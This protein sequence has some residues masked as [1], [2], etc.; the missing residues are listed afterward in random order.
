MDAHLHFHPIDTNS[1]NQA[2]R[3]NVAQALREDIGDGDISASLIGP[4]TQAKARVIT[5]Q[6]IPGCRVMTRA[7]AWVVGPI[8]LAE[9][10]PSP[11]SSR[12]A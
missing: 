6:K 12:N 2:V 10:S 1:L 5:R 7:L 11:M 8:R 4:T 3:D 9:M